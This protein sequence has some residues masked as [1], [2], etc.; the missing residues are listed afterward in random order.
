RQIEAQKVNLTQLM[1]TLSDYLDRPAVDMTGLTGTYDL[2]LEYSLDDLRN[3][4][5]A[6]GVYRPIPDSVGDS[7][8]TS[9]TESL[10]KLGLRLEPRKAPLQVLLIDHV[11]KTPIGN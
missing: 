10:K 2:K 3:L 4:L 5:R 11:E 7:M 1:E 9:V 6:R 8:G